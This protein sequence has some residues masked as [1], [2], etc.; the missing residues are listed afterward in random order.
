MY[1]DHSWCKFCGR[2]SWWGRWLLLL[3][4]AALLTYGTSCWRASRAAWERTL[5]YFGQ[6]QRDDLTLLIK[7][8]IPSSF[9]MALKGDFD[10]EYV[11]SHCLPK[12]QEAR[13]SS[14]L[15]GGFKPVL[16]RIRAK[17]QH[18]VSL[19]C[20]LYLQ[21]L[22]PQFSCISAGLVCLSLLVYRFPM[23]ST[24]LCRDLVVSGL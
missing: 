8:L 21:R 9:C 6:S 12:F 20:F 22:T 4:G 16:Q 23:W 18:F 2:L 14:S 24:A 5:V 17:K 13:E 19:A 11:K 7:L 15:A 3:R 10:K 1:V